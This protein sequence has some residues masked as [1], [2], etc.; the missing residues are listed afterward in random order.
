MYVHIFYAIWRLMRGEEKKH[1]GEGGGG[2]GGGEEGGGGEGE[3][4]PAV[5][6]HVFSFYLGCNQNYHYMR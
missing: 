6:A 2:G 3:E 5:K 4:T 1:V